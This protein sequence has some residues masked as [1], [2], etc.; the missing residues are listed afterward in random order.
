[1]A[2]WLFREIA[3]ILALT[4]HDLTTS[5]PF[6]TLRVRRDC[7]VSTGCSRSSG[8]GTKPHL[9]MCATFPLARRSSGT[10]AGYTRRFEVGRPCPYRNTTFN[11]AVNGTDRTDTEERYCSE[12]QPKSACYSSNIAID[13]CQLSTG[14]S[15]RPDASSYLVRQLLDPM[16]W[17]RDERH[18]DCTTKTSFDQKAKCSL[19]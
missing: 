2:V 18:H 14:A 7:R 10:L 13:R 3:P 15:D 8:L 11:Q 16:A 9:Q 12:S 17:S 5:S 1:M 6:A 4:I 19:R